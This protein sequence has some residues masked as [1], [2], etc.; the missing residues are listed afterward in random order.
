MLYT[1]DA[2]VAGAKTRSAAKRSG[3]AAVEM[4]FVAPIL[5][6]LIF[7][8]IDFG[9][10]MMVANLLT[11]TCREGA[12]LATLPNTLYSDVTSQITTQLTT[13]GISQTGMTTTVKLNGSTVT[14]LSSA[15]SGDSITVSLTVPFDNVS[16]LPTSWFLK[17]KNLAGMAVMVKQ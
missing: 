2:C 13:Q 17:G 7:G 14:D 4:A 1:Q 6:A 15:K 10:A 3:T 16:Y 8:S 12:R 9:R 11:N 5:F